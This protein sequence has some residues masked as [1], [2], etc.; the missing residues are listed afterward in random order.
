MSYTDKD[1]YEPGDEASV[2]T[3]TAAK[4]SHLLVLGNKVSGA[5]SPDKDRNPMKFKLTDADRGG[6][7]FSWL[8]VYN[9]R[10]Y[11]AEKKAQ[12]SLE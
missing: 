3:A 11:T 8:Y 7:A 10:V 1:M 5:L 12:H 9:N 6:M 4:E 2:W